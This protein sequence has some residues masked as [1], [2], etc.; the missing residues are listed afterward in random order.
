MTL[1]KKRYCYIFSYIENFTKEA[2][3]EIEITKEEID[4]PI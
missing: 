2:I 1:P 4:Y 3:I